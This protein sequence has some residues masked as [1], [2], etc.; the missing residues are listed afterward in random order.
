MGISEPTNRD[1]VPGF[2]AL[3]TAAREALE[4][5]RVELAAKAGLSFNTVYSIESEK[6]APS[7]RVGVA[8][9]KA[10][11]LKVKLAELADD[12]EPKK[13]RKK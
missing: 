13:P 4:M 12:I 8:I 5:S 2:A 1:L 7:L 10:L 3:V 11:G 9:A 6:R